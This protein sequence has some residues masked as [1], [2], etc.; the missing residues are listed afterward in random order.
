M[1]YYANLGN[2]TDTFDLIEVMEL[3]QEVQLQ[4]DPIEFAEDKKRGIKYILV[5]EIINCAIDE[6]K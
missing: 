3:Q 6:K 1:D 2:I 4:T 5:F